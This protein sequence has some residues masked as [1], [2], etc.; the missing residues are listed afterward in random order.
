MR[1]T[2]ALSAAAILLLGMVAIAEDMNNAPPK[3]LE[4]TREDV[5]PGKGPAHDAYEAK[6]TAAVKTK[7]SRPYLGMA[8]LNSNE[9]WWII[10]YDSWADL[11]KEGAATD[12]VMTQFIPGDS[13]YINGSRRMI[14]RYRDDLSNVSKPL[15]D[16]HGFA[17]RTTRVRPGHTAEFED[18]L[19]TVKAAF[20]RQ[21]L[22]FAAYQVA[23]GG[24]VGTFLTFRPFKSLAE[25]D[26]AAAAAS[27]F[28]SD[29]QAK[30]NDLA[31]KSVMQSDDAIFMFVPKISNP[32]KEM[33]AAAPDFWTPKPVM[34]KAK[35]PA[36]DAKPAAA[37]KAQDKSKAGK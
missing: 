7:S 13:E 2:V 16:A 14:A 19:K 23:A 27:P 9:E 29:E 26:A 20:A 24:P 32:S 36:A 35:A 18:L 5:K 30:I 3:L 10:G 33:I 25:R 11:E 21:S 37:A 34:A 6:W 4:I 1:K 28:N 15:G 12:S 31:S 17:I 8:S 22:Q